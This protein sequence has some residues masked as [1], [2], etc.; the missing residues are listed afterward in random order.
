MTS[1]NQRGLR[2]A[3]RGSLRRRRLAR[4]LRPGGLARGQR[5]QL[6]GA[7]L[8]LQQLVGRHRI[9]AGDQVDLDAELHL[10]LAVGE[11]A[12]GELVVFALGRQ[13]QGGGVV[14]FVL[15]AA[16]LAAGQV[17]HAGGLDDA[18]AQL[19]GDGDRQFEVHG[20]FVLGAGVG[21]LGARAHL[22]WRPRWPKTM[23]G[24]RASSAGAALARGASHGREPAYLLMKA[25][26]GMWIALR[27]WWLG[28]PRPA[29]AS[30]RRLPVE[31]T[32]P[33]APAVHRG[34][35]S[36]DAEVARPFTAW[37]LGAAALNDGAPTAIEHSVLRR[38]D[39]AARAGGE[40]PLVPRMPSV[41]PKLMSLIRRDDMA[42]AELTELLGREPALLGEVMRIAN[43]PLHLGAHSVT[44]LDAAIAMLGLRGI[45]QVVGRA[46]MAP[47][48]DLTPGRFSASAGTLLWDQAGACAH[49]CASRCAGTADHFDAYLAG[50]VA[51]TGLIVAL[52][53]LDQ[54]PASSPPVS[55]A[56]HDQLAALSARLSARIARQWRL[57][58][59][60]ALAVE[61]LAQPADAGEAS[62]LATALRVA[63][64]A[65]K[66][67]VMAGQGG[68]T[69]SPLTPPAAPATTPHAPPGDRPAPSRGSG[70]R[71]APPRSPRDRPSPTARAGLRLTTLTASGSEKP[72]SCVSRQADCSRLP[73]T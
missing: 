45:H 37:L 18:V 14:V 66:A 32:E 12:R 71:A 26:A 38:L 47:V 41:L 8:Q 34:A 68:S 9:E 7:A 52:R 54:H 4:G 67:Q 13:A 72:P 15:D 63:D 2:L 36:C 56:F 73:G 39:D 58:E 65:S 59:A 51:N 60:V 61:S 23:N 50:M 11:R 17:E 70:R 24:Y 10:A 30:P 35:E 3:G 28:A 46:V 43:S 55:R 69:T 20:V 29:V 22:K 27:Q 48:F 5:E 62:G 33:P 57:S 40:E 42:V 25:P 49:A 19:V 44:S 21:I 1:A 6:G 31:V 16:D 53:L 64:Q